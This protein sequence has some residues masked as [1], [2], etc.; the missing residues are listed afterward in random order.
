MPE[1]LDRECNLH[2]TI[3]PG[4]SDRQWSIASEQATD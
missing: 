4:V 3:L 1:L 2:V